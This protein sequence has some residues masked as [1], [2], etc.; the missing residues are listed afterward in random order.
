MSGFAQAT[1]PG[2]TAS[3]D[4]RARLKVKQKLV[5]LR[6]FVRTLPV[7]ILETARATITRLAVDDRRGR[8]MQIARALGPTVVGQTPVVG[9]ALSF[10]ARQAL[11]HFSMKNHHEVAVAAATLSR[12]TGRTPGRKALSDF[13]E[14]LAEQKMGEI[15]SSYLNI[16]SLLNELGRKGSG[17]PRS[18]RDADV[19]FENFA[20]AEMHADILVENLR[21][22]R[23]Y[24]EIMEQ[25]A[26]KAKAFVDEVEGHVVDGQTYYY[27]THEAEVRSRPEYAGPEMEMTELRPLGRRS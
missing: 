11:H 4:E 25:E 7:T 26:V 3:R 1:F 10:G 8:V 14:L 2:A 21:E 12:G 24:V 15:R 13:N 16:A 19:L 20:L 17:T 27:A 23:T 18:L 6:A 22:L 9:G 5:N